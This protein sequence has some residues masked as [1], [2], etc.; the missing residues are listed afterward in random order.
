LLPAKVDVSAYLVLA[1]DLRILRKEGRD[2]LDVA[3]L[4]IIDPGCTSCS[5][6]QYAW[7][8]PDR[9]VKVVPLKRWC[10]LVT[11]HG[12]RGT[13]TEPTRRA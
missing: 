7:Y 13:T 3:L 12:Y 5:E 6:S 11:R 1:R 2:S 10:E 4:E 8:K 9:V